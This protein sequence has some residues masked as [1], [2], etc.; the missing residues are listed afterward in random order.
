M[1]EN[2]KPKLRDGGLVSK[3]L[4]EVMLVGRIGMWCE[5]TTEEPIRSIKSDLRRSILED[6]DY[7]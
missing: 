4:V 3:L 7:D 2:V 5:M 6:V 1:T